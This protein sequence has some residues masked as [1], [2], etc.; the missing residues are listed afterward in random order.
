MDGLSDHEVEPQFL[1]SPTHAGTRRDRNMTGARPTLGSKPGFCQALT[2]R[3][4][5]QG[6]L[7]LLPRGWKPT[8]SARGGSFGAMRVLRRAAGPLLGPT[9]RR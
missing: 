4:I 8:S 2:G 9:P 1:S 6:N 3:A 5:W 7:E